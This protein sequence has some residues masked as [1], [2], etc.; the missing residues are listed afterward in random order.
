VAEFSAQRLLEE[1]FGLAGALAG[2]HYRVSVKTNL[3][4]EIDLGRI[5]L[6]GGRTGGGAVSGP[7][8]LRAAVLVRDQSGRAIATFGDPPATE[9][10]RVL[11]AAG[12]AALLIALLLRG[13]RRR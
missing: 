8:G 13:L 3:G 11:L 7:A 10:A 2:E 1:A 6:G 9:P 4:P 12:V 5:D